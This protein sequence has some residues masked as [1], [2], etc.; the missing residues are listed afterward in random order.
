MEL[1]P[2]VGLRGCGP[3]VECDTDWNTAL[4]AEEFADNLFLNLRQAPYYVISQASRTQ[5]DLNRAENLAFDDP[6]AEPFYDA[7]HSQ[8]QSFVDEIHA[9]WGAGMIIDIHGQS[10]EPDTIFRGTKNGLTVTQLIA[11]HGAALALGEMSLLGQLAMTT[12]GSVEPMVTLPPESQVEDP[13]YNGGY[14][15]QTYGSHHATGLDA[16]QIEFGFSYRSSV[17]TTR[18]TAGALSDATAAF[19]ELYTVPVPEAPTACY[20]IVGIA[21]LCIHRRSP[22]QKR[23]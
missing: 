22:R 7:F 8:I 3:T 20:G 12:G 15:V 18:A 4:L 5:V 13:R 9:Q 21:G 10:A 11:S 23:K 19:Y 6:A 1:L 2:G 16:Y 14:I 17:A